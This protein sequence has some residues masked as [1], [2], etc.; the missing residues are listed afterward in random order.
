[1]SSTL[2]VP[3]DK[4]RAKCQVFQQ[5]I[6]NNNINKHRVI[7]SSVSLSLFLGAA[8]GLIKLRCAINYSDVKASEHSTV[9]CC[10]PRRLFIQ[11]I[12]AAQ[13]AIYTLYLAHHMTSTF[14][15]QYWFYSYCY[16]LIAYPGGLS[17][18]R[19]L[20]FSLSF[21]RSI[22]SFFFFYRLLFTRV[23]QI[24]WEISADLKKWGQYDYFSFQQ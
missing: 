23:N 24:S 13:T 20:S 3:C 17:L 10:L 1:M 5:L 19:S 6:K 22:L 18:S 9:R 7:N 8:V 4:W 15:L 12:Q 11:G 21:A 14:L 2:L 16:G